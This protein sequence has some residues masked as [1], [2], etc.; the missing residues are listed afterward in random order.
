MLK[1]YLALQVPHDSGMGQNKLYIY[2]PKLD[3]SISNFTQRQAKSGLIGLEVQPQAPS[4][5]SL[6]IQHLQRSLHLLAQTSQLN[7]CCLKVSQCRLRSFQAIC[8]L[9]A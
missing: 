3:R 1:P 6:G 5:A 7:S 2:T 4:M 9:V 8:R